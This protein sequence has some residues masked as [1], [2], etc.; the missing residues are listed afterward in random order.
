[1]AGYYNYSMSNN[2]MDAYD[3]GERPLSKWRKCDIIEE[4]EF[5]SDKL[6][7]YLLEQ[8]T[9]GELVD[10]FLVYR[11]WHHTSK[12]YNVTDFYGI[13]IDEKLSNNDL[14]EI[15]LKRAKRVKTEEEIENQENKAKNKAKTTKKKKKK[16]KKIEIKYADVMFKEWEGQYRSYRRLESYFGKAVLAGPWAYVMLDDGSVVKKLISGKHFRIETVYDRKPRN[17]DTMRTKKI[18]K[19][20]N[21]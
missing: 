14:E 2:A 12:M 20:I 7:G 18:I 13:C 6:E 9:K 1:M 5:E 19:S 10:L 4:V 11:G 16:K 8:L 17:F 21:G 3:D 15:I